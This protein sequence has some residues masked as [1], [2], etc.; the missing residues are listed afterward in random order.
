MKNQWILIGMVSLALLLLL[1]VGLTVRP[2]AD[3]ALAQ[4]PAPEGDTS[5]RGDE[6]GAVGSRIPVQGRLT[7]ASGYPLNG[8]YSIRFRLYDAAADGSVV[9]EDT[10]SVAVTNGLFNSEIYGDCG[11][12]DINGR[13]L[14]LGIQVGT[15]DEMTDRQAIY[16]VPY[17]FS[18]KPGANISGT[19]GDDAILHVEN[20][21]TD[22]RGL[23]GYATAATGINY[24]VVGK[25][26]S[27]TGYGGY[28]TNESGGVAL[29]AGGG[30]SVTVN[31]GAAKPI[32]VGDR[33]RDNAIVAWAKVSSGGSVSAEFGVASVTKDAGAGSYLIALDA[34]AASAAYLIPIAIAEV[35]SLPANAAGLRIVS[36]NQA[37]SYTFR[38]YINNGSGTPVD[39]DF[40]FMV[41]AR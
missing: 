2:G 20:S 26:W 27:P 19:V 17:A 37:A 18:L 12:A 7:D 1:A 6:P 4:G 36:I 25:S 31:A 24:G 32:S 41:T 5:A 30:V 40:V 14:Y 13:Q 38:V 9:C 3:E 23:R 33:Y 35:E 11:S 21:A 22:G 10:N 29:Y 28:F 8:T 15:D 39:N 16:P 34:R